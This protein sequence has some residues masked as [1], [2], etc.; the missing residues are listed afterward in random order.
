MNYYKQNPHLLTSDSKYL[1]A[2]AFQLA[3]DAR[4]FAAI[5][6]KKYIA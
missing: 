6:P 4:S 2:G 3:G 5:L 1:L